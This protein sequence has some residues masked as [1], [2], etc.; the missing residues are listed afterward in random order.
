MTTED[1][2]QLRANADAV[3]AAAAAAIVRIVKEH[4]LA[5]EVL[6]EKQC[7]ELLK[8]LFASGDIIR[9]TMPTGH[10]EAQSVIYIPFAREQKW[11]AKLQ[12]VRK[13]CENQHYV[14]F[15]PNGG[16]TSDQCQCLECVLKRRILE[17]L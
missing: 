3:R 15:W 13:F 4:A 7:V 17:M 8:Q 6:T 14:T 11:I 10:G 9:N 5:R 16:K 12:D 2:N 1:P